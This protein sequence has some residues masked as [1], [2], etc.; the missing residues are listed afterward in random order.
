MKIIHITFYFQE[1]LTNRIII[2]VMLAF[3]K[4]LVAV[5]AGPVI[6]AISGVGLYPAVD[7]VRPI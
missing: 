5:S 1:S 7:V 2:T 6:A 3:G 4:S